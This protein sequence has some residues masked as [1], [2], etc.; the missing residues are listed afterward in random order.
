MRRLIIA[1]IVVSVALHTSSGAATPSALWITG[2]LFI[3]DDLLLFRADK[4]VEGNTTGD[5]V[6]IGST[7]DATSSMG[8][9]LMRAAERKLKLRFYGEAAARFNGS[10]WPPSQEAA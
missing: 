5:V 4:P 1:I 3:K 7:K 2:D 10:A 9:L 8:P 6:L